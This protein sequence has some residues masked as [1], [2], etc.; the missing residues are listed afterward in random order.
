MSNEHYYLFAARDAVSRI[1]QQEL[2][3]L[4]PC[5][6]T[7]IIQDIMKAVY[8]LL[9]GKKSITWDDCMRL[10]SNNCRFVGEIREYDKRINQSILKELQLIITNPDFNSGSALRMGTTALYLF[11]CVILELLYILYIY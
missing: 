8:L 1:S 7:K 3:E 10:L 5:K 2:N 9:R 6:P 4:R 11:N